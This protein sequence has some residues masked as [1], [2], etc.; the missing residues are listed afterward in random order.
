MRPALV[1]IGAIGLLAA[2]A[3]SAQDSTCSVETRQVGGESFRV[4]RC[5]EDAEAISNAIADAQASCEE[6]SGMAQLRCY[7]AVA[8]SFELRR[9]SM[10]RRALAEGGTAE[11]VA[12]RFDASLEE[13][14]QVQAEMAPPEHTSNAEVDPGRAAIRERVEQD[15]ADSMAPEQSFDEA[16]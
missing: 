13:V 3:S 6:L 12:D 16:P 11:A 14:G 9:K 10:I 15:L 7:E 2:G 1:C 8:A 5:D 4:V